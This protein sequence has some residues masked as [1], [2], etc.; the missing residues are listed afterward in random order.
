M[1]TET[2]NSNQNAVIIGGG[3]AGFAT[4]IMLAKRGWHQITVLE[5]RPAADFYEPD[6]SFHYLID[7][8]GQNFTDLLGLTEKLAKISVP[9]TDFYLTEIKADGNR[10]TSKL[11]IIDPNRKTAYWL[12]RRIFLQLLFQEIEENWQ[13]CITVL[14][15]TKCLKIE[16][17]NSKLQIIAQKI[18]EEGRKKE[19]EGRR[20]DQRTEKVDGNSQQPTTSFLITPSNCQHAV[21]GVLK[22][23]DRQKTYQFEPHLLV[24]CDGINSLV[25]QTLDN[26]DNS[27]TNKFKMQFFPSASSGL[28]YKVLTIQPNFPIEHNSSERAVSTMAYA[29][30]GAFSDSQHSVSLGILP[31]AQPNEPRTA[32]IIRPPNHEIWNLPDGEKLYA[33]LEKAFPQLPINQI[34]LPE[35]SDR[36]AK[37]KGGYFPIPQ[38][39]SGLHW[40]LPTRENGGVVLLGDAIHCFPPDIGQG[41]NSALEDVCILDQALSQT[42]DI[43]SDALPLFESLR[44]PDIKPLIRLAQTAFPWQYNQ[45]IPRKRLWTINFFIRL[46][47][48]RILPFIFSPPAFMMIQ[49]HQ[50]SYGEIWAMAQ[51]TTIYIYVFG[52]M[53]ILGSL[54]W[55]F[56]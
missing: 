27:G 45:N 10:K 14:F 16:Q 35:E 9:N 39:C 46:L 40:L 24:G 41:V 50:L 6:K 55:F 30:R 38:Y 7:G 26:W 48:S 3:P 18:I 53:L 44:S 28:K 8:R 1:S 19:E 36:F 13:H 56:I 25:R 15:N 11:P 23:K 54:A 33:F 12:Q 52:L 47:L 51:R 21:D 17:K 31:F 29:I 22:E 4:A 37:S 20:E 49:N 2:K 32:N 42:N 5:K 43:I 34:I